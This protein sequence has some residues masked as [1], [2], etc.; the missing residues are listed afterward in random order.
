QLLQFADREPLM[1]DDITWYGSMAHLPLP[2]GDAKQLQRAL[3][4]QHR[5]EIPVIAWGGERWIRV[6]CHLYN[7]REEI[8]RLVSI[9]PALL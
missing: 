6:S 3:W 2:P 7:T 9:L 8:D 1:P 5:I 4:D